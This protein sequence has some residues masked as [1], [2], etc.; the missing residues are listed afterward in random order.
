[1]ET[2][3]VETAKQLEEAAPTG[4]III[5]NGKEEIDNV[6]EEIG[7]YLDSYTKANL[8]ICKEIY[9]KK[10]VTVE[11]SSGASFSANSLSEILENGSLTTNDLVIVES[12]DISEAITLIQQF[13][14]LGINTNVLT[15]EEILKKKV[16]QN[17]FEELN[18]IKN[19]MLFH[20]F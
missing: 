2:V 8:K 3:V 19:Q 20:N 17:F 7:S 15:R 6:L 13:I 18:T 10:P 12:N 1:M 9:F 16:I 5:W 14:N 11:K 4:N